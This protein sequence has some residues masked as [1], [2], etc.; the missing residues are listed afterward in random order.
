MEKREMG[1]YCHCGQSAKDAIGGITAM[2]RG[3]V[4]PAAWAWGRTV[5]AGH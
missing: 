3:R 5:F 4:G 2:V 1:A